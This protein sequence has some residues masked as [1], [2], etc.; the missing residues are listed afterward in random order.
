MKYKWDKKYL[1]WGVT[2]F[3]VIA[4]CLLF[5][6][7]L[8]NWDTVKK[9]ITIITGSLSSIA[10]GVIIAYL[11][12]PVLVFLESKL[13]TPLAKKIFRNK[14]KELKIKKFSRA[15]GV[16]VT[17]SL[18][19]LVV[20]GFF[21]LVTPQIYESILKITYEMDGYV[22]NIKNWTNS[23]IINNPVIEGDVLDYLQKFYAEIEKFLSESVIPNL[24]T[25]ILNVS[26]GLIGGVKAIGRTLVGIIVSVYVMASKDTF[27]AQGKK[28]IYAFLKTEHAN[29]FLDAL[30]YANKVVG[31]FINGK[32]LDSFIIGVICFIFMW[33]FK[34]DYA[35]LISVIIGVTNIVPFFGP[36]V[37]AIPSA[38][39]LL[40]VSPPKCLVFVIFIIILQQIDGNILGP[41]ILG[42]STGLNS[43]WVLF[44]IL[45][46]GG[47]F[48]FVGMLLGVPVFACIYT[49]VKSVTNSKL[50]DKDLPSD[51]SMF[52]K[53]RR[54][55]ANTLTPVLEDDILVKHEDK[56]TKKLS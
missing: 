9:G 1:Y 27:L 3:I 29:T 25:I 37:G 16:I 39:I 50:K 24:D 52:M 14:N 23:N 32:I 19:L 26:N 22:K 35:I 34:F 36:F 44:S 10:I 30:E 56:K 55:D 33:I 18:F 15:L 20:A 28:M 45:V 7:V 13:F 40:L 21:V 48:G 43:F 41:L 12:D 2:A 49:F 38:L 17:E 8:D 53:I 51:T 47:I 5:K 11:L 54:I 46:G 4:I 42:D 6:Q 31:G